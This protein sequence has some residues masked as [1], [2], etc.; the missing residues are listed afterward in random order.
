MLLKEVE[1]LQPVQINALKLV[2][3]HHLWPRRVLKEG[4]MVHLLWL[5]VCLLADE[6]DKVAAQT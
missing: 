3:P 4:R 1:E 6:A 2:Q 5:G